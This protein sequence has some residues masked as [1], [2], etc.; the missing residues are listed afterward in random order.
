MKAIPSYVLKRKHTYAN[1]FD[2]AGLPDVAKKL[3]ECSQLELLLCCQHCGG[4]QYVV[5]HCKSRVC[6]ICSWHQSIARADFL[7]RL[8]AQMKFPK[9][10]TLTIPARNEPARDSIK[11]LRQCFQKLRDRKLFKDVVGGAYQIEV[12]VK[13]GH[14]HVHMHVIMDCPFIHYTQLYKEWSDITGVDGVQID[15]RAAK[16]EAQIA[17]IVKYAQK[18]AELRADGSDVVKWWNAVKGS[19]LFGTFGKWYNIKLEDLLEPDENVPEKPPCPDCGELGNQFFFRDGS[20]IF[21]KDWIH[22]KGFFLHKGF[23]E[24]RPV[25]PAVPLEIETDPLFELLDAMKNQKGN[26]NEKTT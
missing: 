13:K 5:Y 18:A 26:G 4:T 16:T 19:R 2:N 21:G 12:K 20:M 10:I 9:M 8:V 22:L 24:S 7:R 25:D 15:I 11:Y 3:R 17:Y 23:P 6:P 1:A 14:F